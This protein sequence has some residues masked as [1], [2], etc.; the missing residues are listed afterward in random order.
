MIIRTTTKENIGKLLLALKEIWCI[1]IMVK[2][3]MLT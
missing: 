2:S 1:I 3:N